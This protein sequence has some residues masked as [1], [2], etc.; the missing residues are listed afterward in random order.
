MD[1]LTGTDKEKGCRM[2]SCFLKS[3]L[4]LAIFIPC[5]LS[6][7]DL[8]KVTKAR[9]ANEAREV[10]KEEM[11]SILDWLDDP[12]T[13]VHHSL[14]K[15]P[16]I[17]EFDIELSEKNHPN[18]KFGGSVFIVPDTLVSC[19]CIMKFHINPW[20]SLKIYKEGDEIKIDECLS[21]YYLC[22]PLIIEGYFKNGKINIKD[23]FDL[24]RFIEESGFLYQGDTPPNCFPDAV[25]NCPTI[26]PLP[27]PN[28]QF[29]DD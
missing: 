6:A 29:W 13:L 2:K 17:L 28:Y 25:S 27:N 14:P 16:Y 20:D 10:T 24:R 3:L 4:V 26:T 22:R 12:R 23:L 19:K 15:E 5:S 9:E 18:N 21:E 8:A 7:R 1:F 11:N